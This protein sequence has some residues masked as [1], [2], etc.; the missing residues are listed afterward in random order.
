MPLWLDVPDR[1]GMNA[2]DTS[3]A[4][5]AG[6]VTRP[7]D[8]TLTDTLAWEL[9]PQNPGRTAP[10][11]PTKRNGVCSTPSQRRP[12]A[13]RPTAGISEASARPGTP[14]IIMHSP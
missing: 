3:S 5:A 13:D 1:Y 11:S 2:R 9:A 12:L 7:L 6:L 14:R 10:A 8:Q 4:R